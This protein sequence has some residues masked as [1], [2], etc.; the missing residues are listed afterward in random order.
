M[1]EYLFCFFIGMVTTLFFNY[2]AAIGHSIT[3]LKQTQRS[4]AALFVASEQGLLEVLYLK[5]LAMEEAD[6]SEQNIIAQ[7]YIDQ[8]NI[9]SIKKSIMKNYVTTFPSSYQNILEYST[10]E[11][12]ES[13]VDRT[14]KEK[15]ELS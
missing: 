15:K 2:V 5:Y 13:Y 8:I 14:M 11:D 3:V 7:K 6:R 10:W 9:D 1:L 4:C 12:M